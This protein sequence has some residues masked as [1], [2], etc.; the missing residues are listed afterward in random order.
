MNEEEINFFS[1]LSSQW[2]DETG[3]FGLLHKMNPIRVRFIRRKLV[4][5]SR[6]NGVEDEETEL[7]ARPLKGL[8][9]LDIGCGGGLLS[10]VKTLLS[11]VVCAEICLEPYTA[12]SSYARY[13]CVCF[14]YCHRDLAFIAGSCFEGRSTVLS[15]CLSGG[16]GQGVVAI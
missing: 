8:N 7:S 5:V 2:W 1:R 15:E 14:K 9:V 11:G 16:T 12:R 13:R 6:D 10:E 3:E 4:E